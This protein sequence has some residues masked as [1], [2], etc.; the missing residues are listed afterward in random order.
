MGKHMVSRRT[1][2]AMIASLCAS[3]ARG[4][5]APREGAI[6]AGRLP[7]AGKGAGYRRLD[8]PHIRQPPNL[9]VPTSAAMILAYFGQVMDPRRLKVMAEGHKSPSQRNADFTYWDDLDHALR[10][11]GHR[12]TIRHYPR[13]EAGFRRG[14][15][16]LKRSLDRG[17]PVMIEIHQDVGHTLVV[18]GYH[19]AS[20]IV[21]LADPFLPTGQSRV[22]GY[23]Q[24]RENWHDHQFGPSR[25]AFFSRP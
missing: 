25:S 4:E 11:L 5:L 8:V 13:T 1:T 23:D 17:R 16:D 3:A 22:L 2:L 14:L 7:P 10:Q 19:E 9:C 21:F 6:A 15:R 12:W 24:L 20:G 18:T